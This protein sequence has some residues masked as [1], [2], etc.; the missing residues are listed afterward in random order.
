MYWSFV[1]IIEL[2]CTT[3]TFNMILG[4]ASALSTIVVHERNL[5]L[6][7]SMPEVEKEV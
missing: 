1:G 4:Q 6:V 2:V 7:G 5:F 3:R